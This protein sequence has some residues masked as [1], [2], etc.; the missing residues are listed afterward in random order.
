[1]TDTVTRLGRR[2]GVE[3]SM[4]AADRVTALDPDPK[5]LLAEILGV[6]RVVEKEREIF[7]VEN[8]RIHL[9]RVKGLGTFLELEA[10]F[11]GSRGAEAEQRLAVERLMTELGVRDEDLVD[12][13]Y[14][15]LI[16][17]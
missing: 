3:A 6:Y 8:V 16:D 4:A 15:G 2:Y 11:D 13:S 10:V 14:E 12:G 5:A 1:M 17:G 7:L 9:D